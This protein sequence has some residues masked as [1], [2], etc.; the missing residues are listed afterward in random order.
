M[1]NV[2]LNVP[3]PVANG[4]GASVDVS[5]YD[6]KMTVLVGPFSMGT[7]ATLQASN[8]GGADWA[9]ILELGLKSICNCHVQ[10]LRVFRT[11]YLVTQPLPTVN[12]GLTTL[13]SCC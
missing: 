9:D 3:F 7:K 5:A 13:D 12:L 2:F 6:S 4:P 1:S 11:N 10:L 8:N